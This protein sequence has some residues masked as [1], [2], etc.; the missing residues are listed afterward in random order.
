MYKERKVEA[1]TDLL[2]TGP[3]LSFPNSKTQKK[4]KIA[5]KIKFLS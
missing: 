3:F 5:L 4:K 2:A 1:R